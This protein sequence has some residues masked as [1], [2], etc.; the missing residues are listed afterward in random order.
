MIA[1]MRVFGDR[2]GQGEKHDFVARY[3]R[4]APWDGYTDQEVLDRYRQVTMHLTPS[5]FEVSAQAAMERFSPQDRQLFGRY[6]Q[7]QAQ[8]QGYHLADLGGNATEDR[9]RD[10][11]ILGTTLAR[12]HCRRDTGLEQL[13]CTQDDCFDS[14][15]AK[16]AL[17]GIAAAATRS[18]LTGTGDRT[19]QGPE[20]GWEVPR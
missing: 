10:A 18:G 8:W 14:L 12:I 1:L 3:R 6:L 9:L 16:G 13:L 15:L 11:D 5:E 7:Q 20:E 17:A 19:R 4:G 2:R